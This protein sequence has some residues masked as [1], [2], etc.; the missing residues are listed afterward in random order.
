M[1]K[2]L[3]GEKI[4]H[5]P[6][7]QE[8]YLRNRDEMYL[9]NRIKRLEYL[10]QINPDGLVFA[11]DTE[12]VFGYREAQDAFIAGH[13]LSTI[14]L[15]QAFIEKIMHVH[16]E[17][18]DLKNISGKGLAKMIAYCK[19]NNI[20]HEIVINKIDWLRKIRNPITHLKNLNYGHRLDNRAF[21]NRKNPLI[22]LEDDAKE[23][24]SVMTYVATRGIEK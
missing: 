21:E 23:A 10:H 1:E 24:I 18:I 6:T 7:I 20:G 16:F 5:D 15:S 13:F 8:Q 9:G 22:Q 12:L 4:K 11:G 2:D 17:Q 3:F 19:E 14:V